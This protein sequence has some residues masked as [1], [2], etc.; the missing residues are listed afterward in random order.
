MT[1]HVL[2]PSQDAAYRRKR[3][4]P[5]GWGVMA[6]AAPE[7]S[8]TDSLPF[9]PEWR[10]QGSPAHPP[11][12][13]KSI[14]LIRE[15][16][17][18]ISDVA[19]A[20]DAYLNGESLVLVLELG[21]AKLLLTGDAEV[22]AWMKIL[23]DAD[24]LALAASATFFK[25]GH[26]GS[27]NATPLVFLD[28]HLAEGTPAMMSTQ[29]GPENIEMASRGPRFWKRSTSARCRMHA[30]TRRKRAPRRRRS[31]ATPRT[32]GSTARSRAEGECSSTRAGFDVPAT[33]CRCRQAEDLIARRGVSPEPGA[34]F[35]GSAR[36]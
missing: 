15:F 30:P 25:V 7:A 6:G 29:E 9:G 5:A 10:V 23:E 27:H 36:S 19:A 33:T 16:N 13:R 1:I 32:A 20:T 11:F 2:G 8:E 22:G 26:H 14:D 21:K 28:E 3:S 4:V 31:S 17:S 12:Q 18:D 34:L 35:N 24:S